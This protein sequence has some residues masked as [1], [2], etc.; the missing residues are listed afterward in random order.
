M[1]GKNEIYSNSDIEVIHPNPIDELAERL[2]LE[3]R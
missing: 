3:I 2:Y 1:E